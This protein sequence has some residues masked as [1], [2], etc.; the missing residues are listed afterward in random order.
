[1][2]KTFLTAAALTVLPGL[3][4][5]MGCSSGHKEDM[6]MSCADGMSYDSQTGKCVQQV[7]G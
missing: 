5:A 7:T 2:I 6:A 4:L 1:M 3:A